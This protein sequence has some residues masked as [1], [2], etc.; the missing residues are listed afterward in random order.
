MSRKNTD[1]AKMLIRFYNDQTGVAIKT[2]DTK[3]QE[4]IFTCL[5]RVGGDPIYVKNHIRAWVKDH[6]K[7]KD[8]TE[9]FEECIEA[10]EV[11]RYAF[12]SEEENLGSSLDVI[13][14][15][16][17]NVVAQTQADKIKD[18]IMSEVQNE[19]RSFISREYGP[20]ERKVTISI[21]GEK[22]AEFKGVVHKKFDTVLGMVRK[23]IPV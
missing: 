1:T 10:I 14:R 11:P 21:N 5:D 16:V 23:N 4:I 3:N 8:F 20:I 6:I 19:V 2:T 17:A 22:K 13:C 7:E 12:K 9:R 15:A 18:E